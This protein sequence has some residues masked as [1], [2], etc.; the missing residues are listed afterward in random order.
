MLDEVEK[1]GLVGFGP[2][3]DDILRL[4]SSEIDLDPE[5]KPYTARFIDMDEDGPF[6]LC[7]LVQ[8]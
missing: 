1:V 7:R 6:I 2:S 5:T 3:V 8:F 4:S